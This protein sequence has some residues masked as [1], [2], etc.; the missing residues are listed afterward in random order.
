[1]KLLESRSRLQRF[2]G[3]LG[4]LAIILGIATIGINFQT[5]FLKNLFIVLTDLLWTVFIVS[6]IASAV[7][8]GNVHM[9]SGQADRATEPF[10]FW[11]LFVVLTLFWLGI[12]WWILT[13]S[14]NS[15]NL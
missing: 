3:L 7:K 12:Y 15:L 10:M 8:S 13:A 11:S 4:F 5:I 6:W 9:R 1:M 14:W 2:S